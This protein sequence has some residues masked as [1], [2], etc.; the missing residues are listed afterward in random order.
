MPKVRTQVISLE[1]FIKLMFIW[2]LTCFNILLLRQR[3]IKL[4][5]HQSYCEF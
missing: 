3:V 5:L 1:L 4:N 2:S